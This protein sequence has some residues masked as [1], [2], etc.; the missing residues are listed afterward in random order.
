M[1]MQSWVLFGRQTSSLY[2]KLNGPRICP[3]KNLNSLDGS[4]AIF[5]YWEDIISE[6]SRCQLSH[7]T[8]KLPALSGLAHKF[9]LTIQDQYV[10]GIWQSDIHVGLTW[11]TGHHLGL[12]SR[13]PWLLRHPSCRRRR[14]RHLGQPNDRIRWSW[15]RQ[16]RGAQGQIRRLGCMRAGNSPVTDAVVSGSGGCVGSR[17]R[18]CLKR[19]HVCPR[20]EVD[21]R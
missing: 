21:W 11:S 16:Q 2:Y 17:Y 14:S 8:D 9:S 5:S 18:H 10:V 19:V 15:V 7:E 1:G 20:S 12:A 13:P 6:Y 3:E 4:T